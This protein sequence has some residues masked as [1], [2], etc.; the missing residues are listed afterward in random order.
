TLQFTTFAR[1]RQK[2]LQFLPDA[3]SPPQS[4]EFFGN[5]RSPI[6]TFK[7]GNRLPIYKA[8]ELTAWHDARTANPRQPPPLPAPVAIA[9]IP[10]GLSRALLLFIPVRNSPPGEPKLRI[11]VVDDSPRTLPAGYAAVINAS[12]REYK[13]QLGDKILDVPH[14]IGGKVPAKGTVELRLAAQDNNGWV[15]SGRHT[16]KLGDNDRAS[17]VFFPPTSPTGIAP[18]IRTLIETMPDQ[19]PSTLAANSGH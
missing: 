6:Y 18:I 4:L 19:V 1:L 3:K 13:A 11:Y 7:G 5:T 16:F 14:G 17:L 10:P 2:D 15:I 9:D 8:A 12:G